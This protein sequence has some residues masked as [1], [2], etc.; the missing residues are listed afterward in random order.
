VP[1][2]PAGDQ[3]LLLPPEKLDGLVWHS[4]LSGFPALKLLCSADGR[5][6]CSGYLLCSSL[7]GQNSEQVLT[8]LG[9][10]ASVVVPMDHT[11]P[12]KEDNVDTSSTEVPTAQTLVA[13]SESKA[14]DDNLGDDDP[15]F[16]NFVA[17]ESE[18]VCRM[19]FWL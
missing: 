6:A 10:C 4:G 15:D 19:S 18:I 11:T 5:R 7:Y 1:S 3:V 14:S 13:R 8:I 17:V 12:P 2:A 9:G 16:L